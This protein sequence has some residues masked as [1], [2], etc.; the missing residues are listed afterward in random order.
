M[1]ELR[2]HQQPSLDVLED[3]LGLA[4]TMGADTAFYHVT[5]RSYVSVPQLQRAA[6]FSPRGLL[7]VAER[8]LSVGSPRGLKSAAL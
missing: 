4:T 8:S 3:Y 5:Q 2:D 6:G 1:L 7:N